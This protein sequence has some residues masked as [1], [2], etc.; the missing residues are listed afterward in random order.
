V[1]IFLFIPTRTAVKVSPA[2]KRWTNKDRLTA[3]LQL[4]ACAAFVISLGLVLGWPA[5]RLVWLYP[6][7]AFAW[8]WSLIVYIYHYHT[9]IGDHARFNVRA[10]RQ[11]TFLSWLLL[12]FNQHASHHMYPNIPWHELPEKKQ[13]LPE[14]FK[15]KNQVSDSY[16]SAVLNQLKGPTVVYSED[17]DPTPQLFV[18][19][20]D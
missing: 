10:L 11:H 18:R 20:E 4:L 17:R 8:V 9:T 15:E 19:W 12:N 13:E 16:L 1:I 5:W 3:W 6:F 2:F 14:V 7:L